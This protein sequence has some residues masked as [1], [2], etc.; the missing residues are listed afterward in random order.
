MGA[1]ITSID[2]A[3]AERRPLLESSTAAAAVGSIP[4]LPAAAR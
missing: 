3:A 4:S 1:A 2:A